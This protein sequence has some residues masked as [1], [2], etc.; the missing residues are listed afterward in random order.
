MKKEESKVG[1]LYFIEEKIIQRH[2]QM[3]QN[4]LTTRRATYQQIMFYRGEIYRIQ[5]MNLSKYYYD[6]V[7]SNSLRMCWN[8]SMYINVANNDNPHMIIRYIEET[9]KPSIKLVRPEEF[10]KYLQMS[11]EEI[12][13][14]RFDYDFVEP[15]KPKAKK[16]VRPNEVVSLWTPEQLKYIELA[17]ERKDS[18]ST[19]FSNKSDDERYSNV[20]VSGP[21]GMGKTY[22]VRNTLNKMKK[23]YIMVNG[24]V[25]IF[26]LAVK[27]AMIN[28]KRD[29][30]EVLYIHIDDMDALFKDESSLNLL[31]YA[32]FE[33]K[34]FHYEKSI[35]AQ[36]SMLEPEQQL[37]VKAH[38]SDKFVG[39]RV[40]LENLIFVITSNVM[41]PNDREVT[42]LKNGGRNS[43]KVHRNAIRS[44]CRYRE[45]K[46]NDNLR[47]GW[48]ASTM[49]DAFGSDENSSN[50][51]I[52]ILKYMWIN[53]TN[54]QEHSIRTAEK[55]K[56]I[57]DLEPQAF[58]SVW[59][60]EFLID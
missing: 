21:A 30:K 4:P 42:N 22:F 17:K 5:M 57:M 48:I 36:F 18:L 53:R 12:K 50:N 24:A 43:I 13:N 11:E 47:W 14:L 39:I 8:S 37:A 52:E 25:S 29:P 2:W 10:D 40:P 20:I 31:K 3:V 19:L 23:N 56:R 27:L 45:L 1:L 60:A 16:E 32:L 35:S 34:A 59:N 26:A 55:M 49:L 51:I 44:R 46:F 15:L 6:Y 33:G 9:R 54:M 7:I 58:K 38:M 28:Y 41:L